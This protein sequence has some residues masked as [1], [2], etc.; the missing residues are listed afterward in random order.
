MSVAS[1]SSNPG[2]GSATK[3]S[4]PIMLFGRDPM[5]SSHRVCTISQLHNPRV[6]SEVVKMDHIEFYYMKRPFQK[7]EICGILTRHKYS[8]RGVMFVV[9][10]GSGCIE[11]IK[12]AGNKKG[13]DDISNEMFKVG[14][15]ILVRGEIESRIS[16]FLPSMDFREMNKEPRQICVQATHVELI[17]D[18]S[19][20]L[21]H[22]DKSMRL[23][24]TAYSEN[25]VFELNEEE[26]KTFG[27]ELT[28]CGC[29]CGTSKS[30]KYNM[31]YCK[32]LGWHQYSSIQLPEGVSSNI[33]VGDLIN[34][35]LSHMLENKITSD[36]D[37][38][39]LLTSLN[40]VEQQL[41][42]DLLERIFVAMEKSGLFV[43]QGDDS[44][45]TSDASSHLLATKDDFFSPIL[46]KGIAETNAKLL[47][48]G[49][50]SKTRTEKLQEVLNVQMSK[51]K[52]VP[53][54]R[55]HFVDAC[56]MGRIDTSV[57]NMK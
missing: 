27:L 21:M 34:R 45:T 14:N 36:F 5:F 35:I 53:L 25:F 6:V 31:M 13:F 50:S 33:D 24:R 49:I 3:H 57:T 29:C 44:V 11:C 15:T 46:K 9:D 39:S 10:D 37:V 54:W 28:K 42:D 8:K 4:V 43:I 12:F 2:Y 41:N 52:H 18:F 56:L 48:S 1:S 26:S 7:I 22:W 16:F 20:E 23:H 47:E 30:I 51:F 17:P 19:Y 40:N 55:W 38:K 32:C